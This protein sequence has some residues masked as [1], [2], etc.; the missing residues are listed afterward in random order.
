MSTT[1]LVT[2]V[3]GDS[4]LN[5][6]NQTAR[7]R[8]EA[9]AERCGYE[10]V[11]I[12][13]PIRELPGKKYTWQK[14]CLHELPWFKEG[15]NVICLDS[16]ILIANDAPAFPEVPDGFI[17]AAIDKG[18]IGINSGVLAYKASPQIAEIFEECLKDPDPFWDQFALNRVLRERN[19]FHQIDPHFH[20]MFYLR[21]RNILNAIFQRHW[22]Y[23]SL[24]SKKKL[25][26]IQWLLKLQRR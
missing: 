4:Y 20:C 16:D 2:I 23:H 11:I 26:L 21:D 13:Q 5:D 15:V 3:I 22:I 10:A 8:F 9:Y 18:D 25:K 6:F 19:L 24:S 7:A 1:K 14:L 17:G 12:T